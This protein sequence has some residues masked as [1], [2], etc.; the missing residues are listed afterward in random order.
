MESIGRSIYTFFRVT[1]LLFRKNVTL[2][3]RAPVASL[4]QISVGLIFL[5]LIMLMQHS[6][7]SGAFLREFKE[8]RRP[9][10]HRVAP[11]SRCTPSGDTAL[12]DCY[13]VLY[14]PADDS[15][16]GTFAREVMADVMSHA[17]LPGDGQ[18]GGMLGFANESAVDDWLVDHKNTS[19]AAVIFHDDAF[20]DGERVSYTLQ[21]NETRSCLI[22]GLLFCSDP[23]LEITTP[24]QSAVDSAILRRYT[25]KDAAEIR[26]SV[27]GFPH[28]ETVTDELL[29]D[30]F[31]EYGTQFMYIVLTFNFAVQLQMIVLEKQKRLREIMAQMGAGAGPYWLSWTL[32]CMA[33]N[34][35]MVLV[36]AA[37]GAVLQLEFFLDNDFGLYFFNFFLAACAYSF[38]AFFCSTLV[39]TV[40]GGR[41]LA[42]AYFLLTFL[43]ADPIVRIFFMDDDEDDKE[44]ARG[45]SV[46]SVFP[47]YKGS[48]NL[49]T[50]SKG[51]NGAGM[52]WQDR[53]TAEEDSA[54][55][56]MDTG[57]EWLLIGCAIFGGATWYLDKVIPNELGNALPFYFPFLP[58]FW[59]GRQVTSNA[60]VLVEQ[61][62]ELAEVGVD[63]DVALE[64]GAV[65]ANDFG[66]RQIAVLLQGLRKYFG[67]GPTFEKRMSNTW[68][69]AFAAGGVLG[70]FF[71]VLSVFRNPVIG[72]AMLFV[73]TIVGALFFKCNCC[74]LL[75]PFP[76]PA[77]PRL[78]TD[79][80]KAVDG[81]DLAIDKD[82]VLV[83]LGH[84]GAGKTT[85]I[86]MLT[87]FMNMTAGD[88]LIY[89]KSVRTEFS[90][91]RSDLGV[92]PQ[93]DVLFD[94][95]TGREH[96][97]LFAKLKGI[98]PE[99]VEREVT[100]RLQQVLLED[101][102]DVQAAA[103]SGGMRRR[104]SIAIALI[105][106]PRLVI[107]DEPTTGMDPVTRREVWDMI[108]K[109]K[110]GRSMILTTHSMEEADILGD[111]V[112]IMSK[113]KLQALGTSFSL[114]K[115]YGGGFRVTLLLEGGEVPD[116][117]DPLA[118]AA[119]STESVKSA[120]R[121]CMPSVTF[122]EGAPGLLQFQ[123]PDSASDE[124]SAELFGALQSKK[125]SLGIKSISVGM[126]TLEDVFLNLAIQ[127]EDE[128]EAVAA[129]HAESREETKTEA[130][131]ESSAASSGA[132]A[133]KAGGVGKQVDAL[134]AKHG[135]NQ[136][137][138][139]KAMC[140]II[141]LPV[142]M[143]LGCALLNELL[144]KP[145]IEAE[146]GKVDLDCME[147]IFDMT[148]NL[149]HEIY[150]GLQSQGNYYQFAGADETP[151]CDL[152][153][154]GSRW[155]EPPCL[156]FNYEQPSYAIFV[157]GAVDGELDLGTTSEITEWREAL[158]GK[159]LAYETCN[160]VY[161]AA[162]EKSGELV[163]AVEW[164]AAQAG[165]YRDA[166]TGACI[167]GDTDSDGNAGL[168]APR[169]DVL[170]ELEALQG[171]RD[172]CQTAASASMVAHYV[173]N[174]DGGSQSIASV[175]EAAAASSVSSGVLGNVSFR[176][177]TEPLL[178]SF[179]E[180][181]AESSVE[182]A[183][184]LCQGNPTASGCT[185]VTAFVAAF[186]AGSVQ[187]P[188]YDGLSAACA[189][190]GSVASAA[191]ANF[192]LTAVN[193]S[194]FEENYCAHFEHLDLVRGVAAEYTGDTRRSIDDAL[195]EDWGGTV[196]GDFA[197]SR[198]TAV[199]FAAAD[200]AAGTFDL[201]L[202]YN[203]TA[204]GL[205][206][207]VYEDGDAGAQLHAL[208]SI[209]DNAVLQSAAGVELVTN[210]KV[211]PRY[212]S[213]A[214]IDPFGG[215]NVVDF[216]AYV[217]LPYVILMFFIVIIGQMVAEKSS[218]LRE[219]MLMNGLTLKV[220]FFVTYAFYYAQYSVMIL[221]LWGISGYTG[222][223][224]FWI[225]DPT[226]I[227]LYFFLWGHC[228]IAFSFLV[229][230]FMKSDKVAIALGM[231]LM[232]I[233]VE[234]S[235]T[236]LFMLIVTEDATEADYVPYMIF[237]PVVAVRGVVWLVFAGFAGTSLTLDNWDEETRGSLPAVMWW[238]AGH[239][240]VSL[241]LTW[242]L[243]NV[244]PSGAGVPKHP[245][246]FLRAKAGNAAVS[247]EKEA[248]AAEVAPGEG[249]GD[250]VEEEAR[251]S[252]DAYDIAAEAPQ[253]AAPS[254][255][256]RGLRKV[257][258]PVAKGGP[259]KVAVSNLNLSMRKGECFGLLGHNGAGKTTTISMLCGLFPPSSGDALVGG[260]SIVSEMDAIHMD[261]GIC[262]QH[263]L[264]WGA[265]TAREHVRFYGRLKGLR[266]KELN[267]RG[268][269]ILKAVG[270]LP[271]AD[272]HAGR[273][274]GGMKRRLSVA[275]SLIGDPSVVFLDEPSTGLDPASRR[276]LWRVISDAKRKHDKTI[277]LT[278]HSMEEADVLCDRLGI[279]SEGHL[280]CIGTSGDLKLRF[281]HGYTLS[282]T[283]TDSSTDAVAKVQVLFRSA[284]PL[285]DG[286][287]GTWHFSV[288]RADVD[289]ARTFRTMAENKEAWGIREWAI[290]ET[291]LEEVFLH[292]AMRGTHFAKKE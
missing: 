169:D 28:P 179:H 123:I 25:S 276:Q 85:T 273:Y 93:H 255:I 225:H 63:E 245:L 271:F 202:Y 99:D 252:M 132:A 188:T 54:W 152:R 64:K 223:R 283:F 69:G 288:D 95:L 48:F 11:I 149:P 217:F 9:E 279:M 56:T 281:G 236:L 278:T 126:S 267:A 87:G 237:A 131:G 167:K 107:L 251:R 282:I 104:L 47:F 18:F 35:L 108:E 168:Q 77:I 208:V 248:A 257:F 155:R 290:T 258:P 146:V 209:F 177:L 269:A 78:K 88:A 82:Q 233:A 263:D 275:C 84:N 210:R 171:T 89:G 19:Q 12:D 254:I 156:A 259:P 8:E 160:D 1:A 62:S 127:D 161:T 207:D 14:S 173:E 166:G 197:F 256:I 2:F 201:V 125:E 274:S 136:V 23:K 117:E 141:L 145:E 30:A 187:L 194:A 216:I 34:A 234:C 182:A 176:H 214:A 144:I 186:A 75:R 219:I 65:L 134:V 90:A 148:Y 170:A 15:A 3:Y 116:A 60:A 53:D 119:A 51:L 86:N 200:A 193:A 118:A 10:A 139:K 101:D 243:S 129:E 22:I 102:A 133:R 106:D 57:Y 37:M 190:N 230:T 195:F 24:L 43:V 110:V 26:Y 83:L 71:F 120:T 32:F 291:S 80:F 150:V 172:A 140:G 17:G 227:F 147:D 49:V 185:G 52:D 42:F 241:A 40:D 38:F 46:L 73:F 143:L 154:S 45:L 277:V 250:D 115:R 262:P 211:M 205:G 228:L 266:G 92:C 213:E 128:D 98:A 231:L 163:N 199:H 109:A 221:L 159:A 285:E 162:V 165:D 238:M 105:G 121:D 36:L 70:L 229:T 284:R 137:R 130:P 164:Q 103:Y 268:D 13:T 21:V 253:S 249:A 59:L 81:L 94:Q 246:F 61:D 96:L 20:A 178:K 74:F 204:L 235:R 244:L 68:P 286:M 29:W 260:R 138:N 79:V 66:E 215:Q 157:S 100:A 50:A 67:G 184:T 55:Y 33:V 97:R 189:V 158:L 6:L 76:M 4:S 112:A 124:E 175:I 224:T 7:N 270:L 280:A 181:V 272:R 183:A 212:F 114:K 91:V 153:A 44:I 31:E 58:S 289:L 264:L 174:V 240:I 27:S 122:T 111:R 226:L 151:G 247:P 222:M 242:Y 265:L 292:V 191:E 218:R 41:G 16:L 72:F 232:L 180:E 198:S 5:C 192:N 113:G 142:L 196:S 135:K 203:E 239:W 287:N 39:G 206:E 220:Y 261:M